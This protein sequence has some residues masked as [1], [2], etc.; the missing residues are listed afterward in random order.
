MDKGAIFPNL[1]I[2]LKLQRQRLG[3]KDP[4]NCLHGVSVFVQNP[5]QCGGGGGVPFPFPFPFPLM[6][7]TETDLS[8]FW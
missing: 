1:E 7:S 4:K 8:Q 3:T 6:E 2:I 5:S